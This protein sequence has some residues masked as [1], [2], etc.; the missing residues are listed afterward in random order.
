MKLMNAVYL[1]LSMIVLPVF[2]LG[3][4]DWLRD[5]TRSDA[6]VKQF[7][8]EQNAYAK[9]NLEPV[10]GLSEQLLRE[11]KIGSITKARRP[12]IIKGQFEFAIQ[13]VNGQRTLLQRELSTGAERSLLDIEARATLHSYYQLGAWSL[14]PNKRLLAVAEDITGSESYRISL[15]NLQD[16][17]ETAVATGHDAT[18]IWGSDSA[19]LYSVVLTGTDAR[20]SRLVQYHL[21]SGKHSER[22]IEKDPGWLLSAYQACNQSYAVVQANNENTSEQ[23]LLNLSTGELSSPVRTRTEGAEYYLDVAQDTLFVNSNHQGTFALYR[24]GL[25]ENAQPNQ[26]DL[27]AE[28]RPFSNLGV[29]GALRNFYLFDGGVVQVIQNLGRETL[30]IS[31]FDGKVKN[32][33]ELVES[34]RVGWVGQVGDFSSNT[35]YIRSMSMIEPP[36]WRKLDVVTGVVSLTSQDLYPNYSQLDYRTQQITVRSGE[37]DIP[38]TLA[39]KPSALSKKSGVLLYGYGAYGFT[40][41]PYFMRQTI[42]LLD[43]GVIYAVAH[44]RGGGYLGDQWHESGVGIHKQNGISD[45]LAVARALTQF[46]G[47]MRPIAAVGSSAGGTMI[48]AAIN[49]SPEVFTTAVLNVPFVDV[50]ASMSDALLPLTAQQYR[51]WGNPNEPSQ[52]QAMLAYDPIHNVKPQAYPSLLVRI[53]WNDK[54]VPYWEG[55]KYL[56]LVKDATTKSRTQLLVT[57]FNGGHRTDSRHALEQQAMD[58]AFLIKQLQQAD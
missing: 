5:D 20:P 10:R 14:S 25:Y 51:E 23:R 7:L 38:V 26:L 53:G 48:A 50:V 34:G 18:L 24:A 37:L 58:Y 44:V 9:Q 30:V 40:M 39:Y 4:Y 1:S 21:P 35:L 33:V 8:V 28:W 19:S 55:A 12:W 16:G 49:Q 3:D 22:L 56:S 52:R 57:N 31:E 6:R 54:R 43:K 41:K 2:A 27:T 42:S 36:T 32:H 45:Y 46:K 13:K 29:Q 11:W 47:G 15:I 17:S